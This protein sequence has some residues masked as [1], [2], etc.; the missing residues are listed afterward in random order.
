MKLELELKNPQKLGLLLELLRSLDFVS[1]VRIAESPT[2]NSSADA[3]V[4]KLPLK[5][6]I[7]SIPELDVAAFE[8]YLK[9]TR[10]EWER[11]IF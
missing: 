7:G 10:D 1:Q 9:E 6:F 8:K 4:E 5:A 3:S 2:L 11:D